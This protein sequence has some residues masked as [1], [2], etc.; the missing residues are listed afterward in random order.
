MLAPF[1]PIID[2][3]AME[4]ATKHGEVFDESTRF[5]AITRLRQELSLPAVSIPERNISP[6]TLGIEI[7]MT[8]RHVFPDI[9]AQ[10]P[11]PSEL[12]T[13]SASY[14]GFSR[15]YDAHDR[16]LKPTLEH[17]QTVIPRVGN[18]AY[19]EFSFLPAKNLAITGTE[20]DL[21]YDADI[22][23][24]GNQYSLHMTVAG[25]DNTRDAYA[26]LCALEQSGGTTADRVI[27]PAR[28]L[29]GTWARKGVGGLVKRSSYELMG[30]DQTG[31]EL[32]TL[33]ATSQEQLH[34]TLT[35]AADL[36]HLYH[37]DYETWKVYRGTIEYQLSEQGLELAPWDHPKRNEAPWLKY[38]DILESAQ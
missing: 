28:S 33:C 4:H 15:A 17:I 34:S 30:E 21:L 22:L 37:H 29:R 24:D 3:T 31:Y 6:L 2:D 35:T 36:A 8:W 7:E 16:A 19:W 12:S 25:I 18:D 32:R 5:A 11:S 26:F 20:I 38:V 27:E 13:D 14:A 10:W 9:A 23:R 1:S